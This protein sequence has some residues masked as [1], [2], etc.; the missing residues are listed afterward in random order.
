MGVGGLKSLQK[1]DGPSKVEL[2]E[3]SLLGIWGLIN[4]F[5]GPQSGHIGHF[6]H[7]VKVLSL[8]GGS[9]DGHP[10]FIGPFDQ[11]LGF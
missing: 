11:P 7:V 9:P 10:M 1:Q 2:I 8:F 4:L 6:S 3:E 5:C